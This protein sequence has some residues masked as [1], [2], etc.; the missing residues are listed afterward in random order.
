MVVVVAMVVVVVRFGRVRVI[1]AGKGTNPERIAVT[2]LPLPFHDN[3]L[4]HASLILVW[5]RCSRGECRGGAPPT[6]NRLSVD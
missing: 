3:P 1:D 6:S 2:P 4:L 5:F